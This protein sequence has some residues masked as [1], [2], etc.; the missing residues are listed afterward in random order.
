MEEAATVGTLLE[1]PQKKPKESIAG[2][3]IK[4]RAWEL[5]E[6]CTDEMIG[7]AETCTRATLGCKWSKI[8]CSVSIILGIGN[9]F[10]YGRR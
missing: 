4:P 8:A 1:R 2:H 5:V 9:V 6:R 10:T 7:K 3:L